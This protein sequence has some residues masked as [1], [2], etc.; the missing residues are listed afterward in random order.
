MRLQASQNDYEFFQN[1]DH[2][3]IYK[4]VKSVSNGAG[5]ESS[6]VNSFINCTS[7]EITGIAQP[8]CKKFNNLIN[9][10][11]IDRPMGIMAN[12]LNNNEYNYL[13]YWLFHEYNNNN[14]KFSDIS[15]NFYNNI[16][17]NY[18]NFFS[19]DSLKK[20]VE[21]IQH[22]NFEYMNILDNLYKN[23]NEID[24]IIYSGMQNI[25]GSCYEYTKQCHHYYELGIQKCSDKNSDLYKAL[26]S[27]KE[28]YEESF[29][30]MGI[31]NKCDSIELKELP[32]YDEIKEKKSTGFINEKE[33]S[34][35]LTS[36]LFPII[37][38]LSTLIFFYK[39]TPLGSWLRN[40]VNKKKEIKKYNK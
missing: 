15:E 14:V 37:G 24:T 5:I 9:L 21:K 2:S 8:V 40:I 38:L 28:T 36:I 27:F 25:K 30:L 39:F 31:E 16:K 33:K 23:Y 10:L 7:S 17:N 6:S 34:N 12:S 13:S 35:I 4:A 18:N 32:S 1:M 29:N 11:Y 19:K 3:S 22:M 26:Q 20:A